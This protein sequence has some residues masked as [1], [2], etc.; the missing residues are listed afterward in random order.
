MVL[1]GGGRED[2]VPSDSFVFYDICLQVEFSD[3]KSMNILKSK[4]CILFSFKKE[5]IAVTCFRTL[6]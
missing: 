2:P 4:H 3:L 6:C 5:G 1:G